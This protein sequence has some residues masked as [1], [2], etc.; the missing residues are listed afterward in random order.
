MMVIALT[1][2][3]MLFDRFGY[4]RVTEAMIGIDLHC[5]VKVWAS[6][7][8]GSASPDFRVMYG[9]KGEGSEKD[10]AG[11]IVNLIWSKT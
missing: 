3:K 10:L 4:F 6:E 9:G 8:Y 5:M 11:N 2:F 1:G 7:N